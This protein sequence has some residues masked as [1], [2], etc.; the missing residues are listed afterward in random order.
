MPLIF[1]RAFL[2]GHSLLSEQVERVFQPFHEPFRL[3]ERS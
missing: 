3:P 1:M 2:H